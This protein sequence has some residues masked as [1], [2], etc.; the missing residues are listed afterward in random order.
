MAGLNLRTHAE[1]AADFLQQEILRGRWSDWMPGVLSLET[2][3]GVNRNTLEAA[4]KLLEARQILVATGV[5]RRRRIEVKSEARAMR[6][7][8]LAFDSEALGLDYFVHMNH[9]LQD[10]GYT[11]FFARETICDLGMNVGRMERLVRREAAD[12]W[13]VI[14][15]TKPMLEWFQQRGIPV[16]AIFGRRFG[17]DVA[18]VGIDKVPAMHQAVDM[19]AD[20]GHQRMVW[21][22]HRLRRLP[23][24][25][26][27]E[28]MFLSRLQERGI[29]TGPY[30]LPDWDDTTEGLH[31]CLLNLFRYSP[32]TVILADEASQYLATVQF[33]A[34]QGLRIPQDVSLLC[35]DTNPVFQWL[36]PAVTRIE[37][38]PAPVIR[39]VLRWVHELSRGKDLRRHVEVP[40]KLVLGGTTGPPPAAR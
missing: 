7:G 36:Q 1:Q 39:Q 6:I 37:W 14:S 16:F 29:P 40:A 2:E 30:N 8:I 23:V 33:C 28:R 35:T 9:K 38:A 25:G 4:M 24:P 19:L 22:A 31:Q 26:R 3:L 32:P 27:L 13:L 17:L 10:A 21:L 12:A 20:M 15:G 11:S 34:N 18:A 5:G